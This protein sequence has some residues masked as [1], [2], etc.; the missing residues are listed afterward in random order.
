MDAFSYLDVPRSGVMNM[1]V[2]EALLDYCERRQAVVLRVYEWSEPTLSLGYFQRLQDRSYHADSQSLAVVRRATGG[3]AIVHHHD[4]T[5]SLAIPQSPASVGAAPEVYN[6]VHGA[7]V[8]WLREMGV[9]ASVWATSSPLGSQST[10]PAAKANADGP[11]SCSGNH[12]L[13]FHRRN[14]GDVVAGGYK[15]L[16]SAQ[17]RSKGALLQH[18]SLLLS[19][20]EFAPSLLGMS[21][22]ASGALTG[23]TL[24]SKVAISRQFALEL[25]ER[26]S[27]AID[28]L[29]GV[30]FK[31]GF[32]PAEE[33]EAGATHGQLKFASA[34]WL[35]RL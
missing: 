1:A 22:I 4:L 13:C 25:G 16:G 11:V 2:D 24:S 8:Q 19:A 3:G 32:D 23:E 29:L 34:D 17:R 35:A 7:V 9:P 20:S 12:F 15:L 10:P 21:D 14:E 28:D 5:Y 27:Q 31:W 18:G 26:I 33:I 6:A 30:R